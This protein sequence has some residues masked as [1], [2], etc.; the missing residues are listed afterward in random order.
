MNIISCPL[1]EYAVVTEPS[2]VTLEILN[3]LALSVVDNVN[4]S[5]RSTAGAIPLSTP[6]ND[7]TTSCGVVSKSTNTPLIVILFPVTSVNCLGPALALITAGPVT[8]GTSCDLL[9]PTPMPSISK[10]SVGANVGL[11]VLPT[12]TIS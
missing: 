9:K 1:T 7:S 6:V 10:V 3:V 12:A 8:T 11:V 5:S 4:V 2:T